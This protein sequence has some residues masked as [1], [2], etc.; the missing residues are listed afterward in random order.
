VDQL[1]HLLRDRYPQADSNRRLAIVL[2]LSAMHNLCSSSEQT[3]S[4]NI[5]LNQ[6]I[7][8]EPPKNVAWFLVGHADEDFMNLPYH[9]EAFDYLAQRVVSEGSDETRRGILTS[10]LDVDGSKRTDV[11]LTS[12]AF[13]VR[14]PELQIVIPLVRELSQEFPKGRKG[15]AIV[16]PVLEQ[17]LHRPLEQPSASDRKTLLELAIDLKEWHTKQSGDE[18]DRLVTELLNSTDASMKEVGLEVMTSAE[19]AQILTKERRKQILRQVADLLIQQKPQPDEPTMTQLALVV[20]A[21][22]DILSADLQTNV[23][24]YL[25]TIA[26]PQTPPAY[27]PRALKYLTS[28]VKIPRVVLEGLV[29]EL[30]GYAETEGDTNIRNEIEE[31]LLSLRTQNM[32]LERDLWE[33]FYRYIRAL[34]ANTVP[35]RQERG[36]RLNQKMRQITVDAKKRPD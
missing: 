11:L 25:R 27:R 32:P 30:V 24:Q 31:S 6:F 12:I 1:A 15:K 10:F 22:K 14:R 36:R 23:I 18:F 21:K 20:D 28:F 16:A 13:L 34:I 4:K 33:D 9:Q 8:S 17:I 2:T 35:E 19:S 3:E 26:A 29:P 7:Q 5:I